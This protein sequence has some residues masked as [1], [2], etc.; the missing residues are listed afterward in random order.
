MG[1]RRLD[2]THAVYNEWLC[3]QLLRE[4]GLPVATTDIATFG[5]ET[6]LAVKRFDRQ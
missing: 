5:D 4:L 1:G 2:L 6:V 3:V